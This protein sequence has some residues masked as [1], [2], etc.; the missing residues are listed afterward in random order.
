MTVSKD[1]VLG[2][3]GA[4][5]PIVEKTLERAAAAVCCDTVGVLQKVMEMTLEYAK[6]G[7]NSAVPSGLFR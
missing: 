7:N 5:W 1:S 6:K 4:G 3:V 2:G